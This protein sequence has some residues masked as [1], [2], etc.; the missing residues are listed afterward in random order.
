MLH[1]GEKGHGLRRHGS[2]TISQ[3]TLLYVRLFIG[4]VLQKNIGKLL[5]IPNPHP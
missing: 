5:L 4:V 3:Q 2:P 1:A